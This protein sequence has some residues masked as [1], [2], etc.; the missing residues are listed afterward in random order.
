MPRMT[1]GTSTSCVSLVALLMLSA[2]TAMVQSIQGT[3]T[4]RERMTLPSAAVFEAVLEDVSRADAPA[5]AIGRT[6]IPSPGNPPIA[7]T[8]AYDPAK[9]VSSRQYAV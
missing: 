5:A 2:D 7:F 6:R 8:N 1:I 4:F 9:I 3:A